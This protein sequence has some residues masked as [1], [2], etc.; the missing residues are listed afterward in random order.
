MRTDN[1]ITVGLGEL[2]IS[3]DPSDVLTAFGLGSCLGIGAYAPAIGVGGLLH[4]MLPEYSKK[5]DRLAPKYVDSGL[6]QLIKELEAKGAVREQLH[7]NMVGAANM[8]EMQGVPNQLK[9]GERN[10]EVAYR[11]LNELGLKIQ[12]EETGGTIGRTTRLYVET[13][14]MTVRAMGKPERPIG[15]S[16][17]E[18]A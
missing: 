13:G 1:V 9:I 7:I 16:I 10:L 4:A 8:I 11:I 2:A 12:N 17:P 3:E 6:L 15:Q 5:E 18:P 14:A